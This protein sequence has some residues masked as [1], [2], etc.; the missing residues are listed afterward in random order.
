M[1]STALNLKHTRRSRSRK[2][3]S[4]FRMPCLFGGGKAFPPTATPSL[5]LSEPPFLHARCPHSTREEPSSP[6]P[7]STTPAD[8]PAAPTDRQPPPEFLPQPHRS[9]LRRHRR[10]SGK[11][12]STLTNQLA[13]CVATPTRVSPTFDL[14]SAKP[15]DPS[16]TWSYLQPLTRPPDPPH[17]LSERRGK[18]VAG[19][20]GDGSR[21]LGRPRRPSKTIALEGLGE[22]F[23]DLPFSKRC[24]HL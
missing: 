21:D 23:T 11:A 6:D 3:T 17:N 14:R 4:T 8:R 7:S 22:A 24:L 10:S 20:L 2:I 12:N 15:G 13:S 1:S 19:P 18:K 5:R 9:R 16:P